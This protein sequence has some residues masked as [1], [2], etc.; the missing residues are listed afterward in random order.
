ML[1]PRDHIQVDKRAFRH[2]MFV[3]VKLILLGYDP[4]L[5]GDL[6]IFSG[7]VANQYYQEVT[8]FSMF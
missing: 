3:K 2:N 7:R 6:E 4:G 1:S 8:G 5:W